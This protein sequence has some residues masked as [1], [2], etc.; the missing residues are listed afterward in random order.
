MS[1][2][3]DLDTQRLVTVYNDS[4]EDVP[5]FAAMRLSG[6]NDDGLIKIDKPDADSTID[7]VFNGPGVL[8]AEGVGTAFVV[9]GPLRVVTHDSDDAPAAGDEYG[10]EA[11]GWY[12]RKGHY[13]FRILGVIDG[14]DRIAVA[15]VA[16]GEVAII[17]VLGVDTPPSAEYEDAK[18]V[19]WNTSTD[20]F[21]DGMDVWIVDA[22]GV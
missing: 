16:K 17:E 18:V 6:L 21:D 20:A 5:P 8:E 7:V 11:S 2:R 22:N 13:G 14:Y 19:H 1:T 3:Q 15:E 12:L 10:T 4:G 9:N